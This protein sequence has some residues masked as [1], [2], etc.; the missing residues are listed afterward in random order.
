MSS[1][2][3]KFYINETK[4]LRLKYY[5]LYKLHKVSQTGFGISH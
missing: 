3:T 4:V 2:Q 5:V 1:L